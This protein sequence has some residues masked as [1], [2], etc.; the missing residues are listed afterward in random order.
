MCDAQCVCLLCMSI[1][2]WTQ[3]VLSN[4]F[5]LL[6]ST[7]FA[8]EVTGLLYPHS[9]KANSLRV[10]ELHSYT[11]RVLFD[12]TPHTPLHHITCVFIVTIAFFFFTH[13]DPFLS[14]FYIKNGLMYYAL[15]S[16]THLVQHVHRRVSQLNLV[17]QNT[18]SD[19]RITFEDLHATQKRSTEIIYQIYIFLLTMVIYAM[20]GK[21]ER[22]I[23]LSLSLLFLLQP[24]QSYV[25]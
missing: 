22:E 21:K 14:R 10:I 8:E 12:Q 2:R 25:S 5:L 1:D 4:E 17:E 3:T 20:Q 19:A 6:H 9:Q 15:Q 11:N 23:T 13:F 7:V 18:V 16:T 24:R